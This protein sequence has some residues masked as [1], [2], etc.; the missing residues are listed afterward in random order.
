MTTKP[1]FRRRKSAR[2]FHWFSTG[3]DHARPNAGPGSQIQPRSSSA[4]VVHRFAG[5]GPLGRTGIM[6]L[7]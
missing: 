2:P 7:I 4:G 3:H 5:V 1:E 6:L